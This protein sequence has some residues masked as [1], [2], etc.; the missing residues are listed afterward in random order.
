MLAIPDESESPAESLKLHDETGLHRAGP[1]IHGCEIP[2]K[3]VLQLFGSW[4][5][6]LGLREVVLITEVTARSLGDQSTQ[7][8]SSGLR[9]G[10][11]LERTRHRESSLFVAS[12]GKPSFIEISLATSCLISN[13]VAAVSPLLLPWVLPSCLLS[14]LF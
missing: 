11:T 13:P 4:R 1:E 7:S 12:L 3:Y 5:D 14:L 9:E 6:W 2:P 10:S 8:C